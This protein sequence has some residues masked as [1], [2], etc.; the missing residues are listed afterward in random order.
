MIAGVAAI[1]VEMKRGRSGTRQG[2]LACARAGTPEQRRAQARRRS[3][4]RGSARGPRPPWRGAGA[5]LHK[6]ARQDGVQSSKVVR[7]RR[8]RTGRDQ[9]VACLPYLPS[10]R[11]KA[12][13]GA[14]LQ[15]AGCPASGLSEEWKSTVP[16]DKPV[17]KAA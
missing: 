5:G 12:G 4:G 2:W 14:A 13:L 8:S 3:S 16:V 10:R 1:L 17:D 11:R 7:V 9:R 6:V 15:M